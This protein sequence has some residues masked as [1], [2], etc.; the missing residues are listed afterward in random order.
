MKFVSLVVFL[1]SVSSTMAMGAKLQHTVVG[2]V[3]WH[4][5]QNFSSKS[6]SAMGMFINKRAEVVAVN[7]ILCSS[8]RCKMC[9]G[10][11]SQCNHC[12]RCMRVCKGDFR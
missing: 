8:P 1:L 10:N 3:R 6:G 11:C 2:E 4:T 12:S 5:K 9:T 7:N